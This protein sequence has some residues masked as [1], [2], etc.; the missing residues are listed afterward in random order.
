MQRLSAPT[1]LTR[2]HGK[3]FQ[4]KE[5][6]TRG[7]DNVEM[8]HSQV[9]TLEE[10]NMLSIIA[11]CSLTEIHE[12]MWQNMVLLQCLVPP[13]SPLENTTRVSSLYKHLYVRPS[14]RP[15]DCP[16]CAMSI[17]IEFVLICTDRLTKRVSKHTTL[18]TQ[19]SFAITL[20]CVQWCIISPKLCLSIMT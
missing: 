6:E 10:E 1:L 17:H 8:G 9:S 18:T 12:D 16:P 11:V 2:Q 4:A 19:V 13:P 3:F 15:S 20:N 14:V 7:T 5:I